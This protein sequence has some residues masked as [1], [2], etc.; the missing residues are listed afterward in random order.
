MRAATAAA[1]LAPLTLAWLGCQGRA[2]EPP[3]WTLASVHAR[4]GLRGGH[5]GMAC[6]DCHAL[7]SFQG[8]SPACEGC[9]L[10][11]YDR[12]TDPDH[13]AEG[14]GTVC[15]DCHASVAWR[16]AA[17]HHEEFGFPLDGAHREAACAQCH[18]DG[19]F[20]DTPTA[21]SA[22]HAKA[23]P[24]NH[25]GPDCAACHTSAAWTPSTFDHE[26][27][28]PLRA[29]AHRRYS[30]RCASCHLESPVYTAFTCT[31]CHDGEH[32]RARTDRQH[33]EVRRYLYASASCLDCHPHGRGE[34]GEEEDED[35]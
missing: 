13:R 4:V 9:H 22:C 25:F 30:Q 10:A 7:P 32:S 12:T 24:A 19:P 1:L 27:A 28:F 23:E 33:R 34:E 2:T 17:R 5:E 8:A 29:G 11:A 31:D 18:A 14:F 16:P 3:S 15:A 20:A 6:A 21:C 35:E 26:G